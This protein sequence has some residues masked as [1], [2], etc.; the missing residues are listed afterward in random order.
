MTD[1]ARTLA[2]IKALLADNT[3]KDISPQDVR[4]LVESLANPVRGGGLEVAKVVQ[5]PHA[6]SIYSGQASPWPKTIATGTDVEPDIRAASDGITADPRN[7]MQSGTYVSATFGETWGP[8]SWVRAAVGLWLF[9]FVV[10]WDGNT[11]GDREVSMGMM[12]DRQNTL[13]ID[14]FWWAPGYAQSMGFTPSRVPA[15]T[16]SNGLQVATSLQAVTPEMTA[17]SDSQST[18]G[19]GVAIGA[20]VFQNSGANRTIT[21]TFMSAIKI[22]SL[23][24][25]A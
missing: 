6:I 25:S 8:G 18:A 15:A 17:S 5:G 20:T 21:Y 19:Q 1:T 22:G 13:G 23:P 9:S 4:D 12:D 11:T 14:S 24:V 2:A 3:T 7:M 16:L 10:K